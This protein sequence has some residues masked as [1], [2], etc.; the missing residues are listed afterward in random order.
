MSMKRESLRGQ[1]H[2]N[3]ITQTIPVPEGQKRKHM[4]VITHT[5]THIYTQKTHSHTY[6]QTKT[7]TQDTCT[8]ETLAGEPEGHEEGAQDGDHC[9]QRYSNLCVYCMYV[10]S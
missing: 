3:K 1:S 4:M 6:T 2:T 10:R 7:Q 5:I 8:T 9:S